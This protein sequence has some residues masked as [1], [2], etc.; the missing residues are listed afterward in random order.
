MSKLSKRSAFYAAQKKR[1]LIRA[2][3]KANANKPNYLGAVTSLTING[4]KFGAGALSISFA[5][6]PNIGVAK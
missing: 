6:T 3:H 4:R 1:R 2:I 5:G